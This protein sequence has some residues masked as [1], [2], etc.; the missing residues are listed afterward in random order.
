MKL[1][2]LSLGPENAKLLTDT[3]REALLN[4]DLVILR[5]ERHPCVPYLRECCRQVESLDAFYEE[6]DDFD[7]MHGAMAARILK[8]CEE[9]ASVVYACADILSDA[10]LPR[11]S[12]KVPL[13]VL[14]GISQT[15]FL[16]SRL[17]DAFRRDPEGLLSVPATAVP[18]LRPDPDI[19]L[20][21]SE[22]NSR[23]LAGDIK[24]LLSDLYPDDM[25]IVF[26]SSSVSGDAA[27]RIIPLY[28]LDRQEVYDHTT[29]CFLPAVPLLEKERFSVSDLEEIMERLRGEDGCSWDRAQTHETLRKYLLEEAYEACG[30]I[31]E[32]DDDHLFEELGDVLLQIVFHASIGKSQGSFSMTDVAT[33]ICRKMIHRHPHVFHPEEHIDGVQNWDRL[34]QEEQ[35]AGTQAEYLGGV[36]PALPQLIR[37]EKVQS[38]AAKV[39][40]RRFLD[41]MICDT[42]VGDEEHAIGAMLFSQVLVCRER[43]LD[44]EDLL[45]KTIDRFIERFESLES[46]VRMDGKRL[47]DLTDGEL[48]VYLATASEK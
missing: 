3:A 12:G 28:D 13:T 40:P 2:A 4:S 15:D 34:K 39:L 29:G 23:T 1:T 9:Y 19:P 47:E 44:A 46:R 22:L 27:S 35:N 16:L 24:I 25:E 14:P 20:L 36:S 10:L 48:D 7:E 18:H 38:R 33:A 43:Q 31:D 17:P 21:V 30:A 11:L 5:T 41:T 45:R 37:A 6:Y 32:G 8:A 26:F 42:D